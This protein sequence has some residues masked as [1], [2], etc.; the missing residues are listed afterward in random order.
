MTLGK[1][2]RTQID[3]DT[4]FNFCIYIKDLK[5]DII[6]TLIKMSFSDLREILGIFILSKEIESWE[7]FENG[8][9]HIKIKG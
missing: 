1:L 4:K 9:I 5:Y 6:T 7:Q 8:I 3:N 2:I